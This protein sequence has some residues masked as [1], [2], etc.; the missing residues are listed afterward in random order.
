MSDKSAE[1]WNEVISEICS[2]FEIKETFTAAYH[3]AWNGF[4]ERGIRKIVDVLR[5]IVNELLDNWE[6]WLPHVAA[7]LKTSDN[8]FTG[9]FPYYI[10]YGVEKRLSY[11]FLTRLQQPVDNTENYARQQLRVLGK[12]H[13]SVRSKLKATKKKMMANQHKRAMQVNFKPGDIVM[14]Q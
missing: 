14:I 12:I 6:D 1:F 9:K 5:P 8:Y 4:V 11:D 7:S 2:Q 13:A 3:P 10:L